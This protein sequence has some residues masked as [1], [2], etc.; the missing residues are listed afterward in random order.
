MK[1]NLALNVLPSVMLIDDDEFFRMVLDHSLKVLGLTAIT[2]VGDGREALKMLA[3]RESPP[4][5]LICDVYMP[6]MDGF[7]FLE[8]LE[9]T[10]Y[11][12]NIILM[13][14]ASPEMLTVARDLA[15]AGGLNVVA[16][17]LKPVSQNRLAEVLGIDGVHLGPV[18]SKPHAA[19]TSLRV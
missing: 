15:V 2:L 17:L 5:F 7:E 9:R 12:G 18:V 19:A 16:V 1:S 6:N 14:G 11:R 8:F 13:S 10:R 4:D 3:A